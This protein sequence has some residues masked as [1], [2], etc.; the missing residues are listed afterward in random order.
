MRWLRPPRL[1]AITK[2]KYNSTALYTFVRLPL[3]C[4]PQHEEHTCGLC[5][6]T[7]VYHYYGLYCA[8]LRDGLCTDDKIL[9]I[10]GTDGVLPSQMVRMLSGDGFEM[11]GA[12]FNHDSLAAA[13]RNLDACEPSLMLIDAF[14]APH[15]VVLGGYSDKC[16]WIMDSIRGWVRMKKSEALERVRGIWLL[17]YDGECR[18]TSGLAGWRPLLAKAIV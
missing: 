14:D 13:E 3:L 10:P 16:L 9:G 4:V 15:W 17:K 8:H 7:V 11:T 2:A 18:L 12:S 1:L 6:A 5:A